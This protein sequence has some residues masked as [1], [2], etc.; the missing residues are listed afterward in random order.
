MA[1]DKE[2][3]EMTND[4]FDTHLKE[5]RKEMIIEWNKSGSKGFP[6]TP[7]ID[8]V[9]TRIA[10]AERAGYNLPKDADIIMSFPYHKLSVIAASHEGK[11]VPAEVLAD[12]PGL[13]EKST[14]TCTCELSSNDID[15]IAEALVT[16]LKE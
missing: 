3:W 4:E 16:K 10:L 14:P 5:L 13:I 9:S 7:S 8:T 15:R 1:K 6:P 2:P 11:P 12:Y